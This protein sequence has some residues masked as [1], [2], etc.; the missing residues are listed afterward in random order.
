M[1]RSRQN[2]SP[3][4]EPIHRTS[5]AVDSSSAK[6]NDGITGVLDDEFTVL[7]RLPEHVLTNYCY[8]MLSNIWEKKLLKHYFCFFLYDPYPSY[9]WNFIKGV[10]QASRQVYIF[11]Y[12]NMHSITNLHPNNAI[13]TK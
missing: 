7:M 13:Y 6:I 1:G 3:K 4:L 12:K 10:Q 8:T 5:Q 9:E 2:F 11:Y